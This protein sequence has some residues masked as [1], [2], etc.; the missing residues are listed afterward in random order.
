M[1]TSNKILI[2]GSGQAAIYAASEIRKYD[3]DSSVSILGNENFHPYERPP[4]SK[5]FLMDK[6]KESWKLVIMSPNVFDTSF[7]SVSYLA[8]VQNIDS[9]FIHPPLKISSTGLAKYNQ[10][11]EGEKDE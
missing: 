7:G 1:N 2:L 6:K 9:D 11:C 3:K 4:L 8:P 10:F 5:D